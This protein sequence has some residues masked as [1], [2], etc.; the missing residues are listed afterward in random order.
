MATVLLSPIFNI[1]TFLDTAGKPLSGGLIY[2]Y[3]GGSSGTLLETYTS[4]SG[5]VQNTN[6]LVLNSAGQLSTSIWLISGDTYNLVLT[7]SD[8]T[9]L[10][11]FDGVTGVGASTSGGSTTTSAVWASIGTGTFLTTTSFLVP[12]NQT[13][14]LA[15]GNR[16]RLTQSGAKL[17]GTVSAISYSSPNSTVTVLL[18]AGVLTS[19]LSLVEGSALVANGVTVDAGAVSWFDGLTYSTANT[20][21][22][23]VTSIN[24]TLTTSIASTEAKRARAALV[25]TATGTGT[26]VLTPTPAISAYGTDGAWSVK[27][28]GAGT[29]PCTLNISGLGALAL[30]AYSS[31]GAKYSISIPAGLTTPVLYDGTDLIVCSPPP[32]ATSLPPRGTAVFTSN[33]SWT[34]PSNVTTVKVTSVGGG[35]GGGGGYTWTDGDGYNHDQPGGA[36]GAGTTTW[37][38]VTVIPGTSYPVSIGSM[39]GGGTSL[40]G[41]GTAGGTTSFG[42]TLSSATG[43]QP[44]TGA[45]FSSG[46]AGTPG[47]SGTGLVLVGT[48]R[49]MMGAY[50]AG[51]AGGSGGTGPAGSSGGAGLCVVEY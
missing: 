12:G 30:K 36:G 27:F 16:V 50:G 46:T 21:G 31:A 29:A 23:K 42:I 34:C 51:G 28:V 22:A 18:D 24:T 1:P 10:K 9:V 43:G 33:S 2:T 39:G 8:G 11:S 38:Y 5:T 3:V 6:P 32:S 7:S 40:G 4:A 14:A 49:S 17:Y 45:S 26:Y 20:L 41:T 35:G 44:G 37:T 15:V 47:S 13:T 19:G 48:T 25:Q